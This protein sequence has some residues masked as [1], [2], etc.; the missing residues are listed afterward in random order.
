MEQKTTE[1]KPCPKC[2]FSYVYIKKDY[3]GIYAR[4]HVCGYAVQDPLKAKFLKG[5]WG[6]DTEEEAI[7]AWNSQE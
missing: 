3:R 1:L 6:C 7:E 2:G 5:F 4:C